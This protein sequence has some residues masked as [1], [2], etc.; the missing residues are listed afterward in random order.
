MTA[1]KEDGS[2]VKAYYHKVLE[3]IVISVGT[4]F[5]ENEAESVSK[6]DCEI[7]DAK[8]LLKRLYTLSLATTEN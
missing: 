7:N 2:K 4:E 6:Q 8:R 5:I 3:K 1:P